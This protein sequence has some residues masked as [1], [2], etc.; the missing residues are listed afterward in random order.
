M[1]WFLI[2]AHCARYTLRLHLNPAA[3]YGLRRICSK[4]FHLVVLN[5]AN[6]SDLWIP[7]VRPQKENR[8]KAKKAIQEKIMYS[9]KSRRTKTSNDYD[10]FGLCYSMPPIYCRAR[11]D[12]I[13]RDAVQ[14]AVSSSKIIALWNVI[15]SLEKFDMALEAL[16][17]L[18]I[19]SVFVVGDVNRQWSTSITAFV[20]NV[21]VVAT[22][23]ARCCI[24]RVLNAFSCWIHGKL[25]IAAVKNRWKLLKM[26]RH[27]HVAICSALSALVFVFIFF[28][29]KN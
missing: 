10:V 29:K 5:R 20:L 11:F 9:T 14:F 1:V 4:V 8:S 12:Q 24:F 13:A 7:C 15:I 16:D 3:A 27:K 26:C 23:A 28:L 18:R 2:F 25:K 21:V 22:A 6:G 19:C 17:T